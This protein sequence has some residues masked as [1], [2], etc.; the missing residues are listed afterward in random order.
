MIYS[1]RK[2]RLDHCSEFHHAIGQLGQFACRAKRRSKP[3]TKWFGDFVV[4][5]ARKVSFFIVKD[6]GDDW[7]IACQ[8][9]NQFNLT[10]FLRLCITSIGTLKISVLFHTN[11]QKRSRHCHCLKTRG[12]THGT[13][14]LLSRIE[15][16]P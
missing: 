4:K 16:L 1:L 12:L 9:C 10:T 15:C 11:G 2:K 7:R 5:N 14:P 8:G 3:C 6:G 13:P